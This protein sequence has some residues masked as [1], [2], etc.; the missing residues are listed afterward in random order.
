MTVTDKPLGKACSAKV[1]R[2]SKHGEFKREVMM[3]GPVGCFHRTY[4]RKRKMA[5]GAFSVLGYS[6]QSNA[7]PS[8]FLKSRER[9]GVGNLR[10]G[11]D[12]NKLHPLV[13][14]YTLQNAC[15]QEG[16]GRARPTRRPEATWEI[17]SSTLITQFYPT[18]LASALCGA[19]WL[20]RLTVRRNPL[21]NA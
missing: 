12:R 8:E 17:I 16:S 4:Y 20:S 6:S 3:N 19:S 14:G 7:N 2:T 11:F 9:P 10:I 21:L 18:A 1:P 13:R 5:F 15:Q